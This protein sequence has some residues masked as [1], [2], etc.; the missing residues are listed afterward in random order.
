MR[1]SQDTSSHGYTIHAVAANGVTVHSP[2]G[3]AVILESSFIIGAE[4][5]ITDWQPRSIEQLTVGHFAA[6]IDLNPEVVLLGTGGRLRFP[7][8]ALLTPFMEAGIGCEV[9]DTAAACRTYNVLNGEGRR[10]VAALLFP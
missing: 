4:K 7:P 1:F 10:V 6:I 9:M 3:G 2:E 8:P 5:L